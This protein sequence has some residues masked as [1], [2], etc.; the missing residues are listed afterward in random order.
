MDVPQ[1][2]VCAHYYDAEAD[3]E[4]LEF[5]DLPESWICPVCGA[6]KSAYETATVQV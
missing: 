4:D 6:P 1:C 2:K 5:D 3:G